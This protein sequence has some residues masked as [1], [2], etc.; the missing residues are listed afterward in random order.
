MGTELAYTSSSALWQRSP[1][2]PWSLLL[3]YHGYIWNRKSTDATWVIAQEM[4][5]GTY[6]YIDGVRRGGYGVPGQTSGTEV[7][8]YHGGSPNDNKRVT[9]Y[10]VTVAPGPHRIDMRT[11]TQSSTGTGKW[12][13][14]QYDP[15]NATWK[16][17]FG[18]AI[19]WNG[20]MSTNC[21][22]YSE[23]RDPGDGSLFTVTTNGMD[24]VLS[25]L[26]PKFDNLKFSGGTLDARGSSLSVKTL[27]CGAGMLTNSNAYAANGT[28]TIGEKLK[29]DGASYRGGTLKIQGKLKLAAGAALDCED[30]SLLAHGDYALVEATD[31]IEGRPAFGGTR[32]WHIDK[33]N[34]DGK[35][36]LALRWY[37]GTAL[38]LR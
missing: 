28:F 9:F 20:T 2:Q 15:T 30:L 5:K 19:D 29:V 14:C 31:G 8:Y 17:N 11:Y 4:W 21:V 25:A 10:T 1:I 37:L 3:S 22:D 7:N 34:V 38:I 26:V 32:G 16:A 13:P 27:E 18:W 24:D 6:L 35:E 33:I 12:G 23:M 36:T